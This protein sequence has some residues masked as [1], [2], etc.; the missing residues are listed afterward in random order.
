MISFRVLPKTRGHLVI[1]QSAF[2]WQLRQYTTAHDNLFFLEDLVLDAQHILDPEDLR[3]EYKEAAGM[4][5]LAALRGGLAPEQC[6]AFY[7]DGNL[8]VVHASNVQVG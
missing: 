3:G 4:A 6:F 7:R 1:R 8:L 2:D 5:V